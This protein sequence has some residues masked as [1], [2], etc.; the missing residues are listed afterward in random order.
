MSTFKFAGGAARLR[1]RPWNWLFAGL[2]GGLAVSAWLGLLMVRRL[3]PLGQLSDAVRRHQFIVAYQPIVDLE[4][5][6][7]VGA[8]ALV[9]W[10]QN[11]RVVRPDHFIPLAEHRGLIQAITDQVFD[12]ILFELGEF[13]QRYREMYVSINLSAPD[14]VTRRFL[15]RL[16]PA[17][18]EAGISPQ[19][20][21]IEATE[22]CFLDADA[23]KEVIQAFR[24]AGHP[25][26]IDDFGTGYSSLSHLQNFQVDVLKIDKSFVDTVGQDA[27]S[28]SVASHIVDMAQ[29][30]GVQVVAEGIEHEEQACYLHARGAQF[31]QGWL[32][33]EPLSAPDFIRYVGRA[34]VTV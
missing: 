15:D 26:Y 34:L 23:A 11:N 19:Q 2:A 16:T 8:E 24:D 4:T 13:L 30:L 20:I 12:T 27:A 10:K 17:L 9:R 18:A 6:R 3:S 22:R 32:F 25:V 28:S 1:A 14:L 29:T 31:G 21:R 7:C 5:R 33:S